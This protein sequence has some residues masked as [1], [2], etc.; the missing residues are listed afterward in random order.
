M[1][2]TSAAENETQLLT[3]NGSNDTAPGQLLCSDDFY[4]DD[5]RNVCFPECGEWAVYPKKLGVAMNTLVILS[6]I[7]GIIGGTMV[8]L[9]SCFNSQKT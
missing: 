1:H 6:V 2:N 3:T 8:I 4:L 9:L 7:I 5:E